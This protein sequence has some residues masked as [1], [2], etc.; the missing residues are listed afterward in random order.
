[1]AAA[2]QAR[3]LPGVDVVRVDGAGVLRGRSI[4]L[5]TNHTGRA[6]DGTPTLS[7]LRDELELDVK[8]LFSPEHGFTGAVAAGDTIDSSTDSAGIPIYSLYGE[9]RSPTKEMLAGV[10]TLVFDIQDIGVRFYTYVSTMKLAMEKASEAGLRFVVLDRPNPNGGLKVEGPVLDPEFESFV[11][12]ASMPLVHGMT[13]GELARWFRSWIPNGEMLDLHVVPVRGLERDMMWDETGL[14][15]VAPSPNIRTPTAAYV[16]PGFGLFE[17]INVSEGRG[18]EETFET[19]GAPWVDARRLEAA[20]NAS[21][22]P[23]VTFRAVQFTPHAL[24]SAPR[25]KY[26]DE[27]CHGVVV[28]LSSPRRFEAVRTGLSAIDAI[29]RHHPD[30]F[31]WVRRGERYWVDLL[32]GTDRPRRALEAGRSV[33][34]VLASEQAKVDAFVRARQ[35]HLLY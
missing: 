23:G 17:G 28:S 30:A 15:W 1:M 32:L 10:D 6:I 11:G 27:L 14:P 31:S 5:I 7:V 4:G 16:Y 20:L 12:T 9:T 8:A 34:E 25:P 33:D 2:P 3:V 19:V 24:P 22:F 35:P 13:L 29:R 26:R 18:L 21:R